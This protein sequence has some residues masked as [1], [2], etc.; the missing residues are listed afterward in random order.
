MFNLGYLPQGNRSIRTRSQT[1][2]RALNDGLSCLRPGGRITI[3]LS[4]GDPVGQE[5]EEAVM[6]W[7]KAIP[8]D[9]VIIA[10]RRAPRDPPHARW[11]L[12]LTVPLTQIS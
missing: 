1:T 12:V 3:V 11:V 2:L 4:P 7:I 8:S 5:E 9:R 10:Q 6:N